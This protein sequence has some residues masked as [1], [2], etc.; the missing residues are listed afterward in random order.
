MQFTY[1]APTKVHFGEI[2]FRNL[3]SEIAKNGKNILILTGGSSTSSFANQIRI[4]LEKLDDSIA[5]QTVGGI[6]TNPL[7]TYIEE[8]AATISSPDVIVSVGGGSVHDSAKALAVLCTHKG[9]IEQYT[10][11]GEFSVPGITNR[12]L[13]VVTIPTI[14]GTGSE[15]SPAALIRIHDKKRN[16]FSPYLYPQATFINPQ[17]SSTLPRNL[18]IKAS[19]DALV[20]GIES[21][22]STAA[23]DFSERF[24]LSAIERILTYLPMLDQPTN[25]PIVLEQCALASIESLYAVGQSTVGAVHAISD[26]LSGIFNIHHGEAVGFLLPYVVSANYSAS[27]QKYDKIHD[28][29]DRSLQLKTD[30]LQ[31][32]IFSFYEKIGF[33]SFSTGTA[34]T[35]LG[36][37]KKLRQCVL[38][39]F[40][41]DMVG[42]PQELNEVL[43]YSILE[44]A[45]SLGI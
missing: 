11:D 19:L 6:T 23:Q 5:I 1:Y 9:A 25:S 42:N 35:D 8:V 3:H 12:T 4:G 21:Y 26:P 38:D 10:I 33:D 18:F 17:F 45:V 2:D 36:F 29:I 32:S 31:S 24:S 7:A 37:S 44:K 39:S 30:T 40:N 16:I 41:G 27:P 28:L 14:F 15:V 34:L 22:V 43:V 13:P 20:Q